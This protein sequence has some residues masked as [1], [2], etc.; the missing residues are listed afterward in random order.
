M[1]EFQ[2]PKPAKLVIA[3][4]FSDEARLSLA[5][6]KLQQPFGEIDF[7]SSFFEFNITNYYQTEM[8]QPIFRLFY[9]FK[10]LISPEDLAPIK[11]QTIAI[12]QEIAIANNRKVNLDPGY[13]DTDKFVFAST[14]YNGDKIYLANG[15]WA[16]MTLRY[17]KGTFLPYPWSFPDFRSGVYDKIFLRIRAIY[18]KQ[19]RDFLKTSPSF[20][21][22]PQ[23]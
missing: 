12:E 22:E 19:L 11:L 15:I 8:G 2:K 10:K 23:R 1:P 13:L 6:E 14:K 7:T 17:E 18:K 3:V 9:S 20:S 5:Q 16:D 4:L 21:N